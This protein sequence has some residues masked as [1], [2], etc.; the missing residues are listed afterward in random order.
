MTTVA[1][2]A[3][4]GAAVAAGLIATLGAV[5]YRRRS[6]G[7]LDDGISPFDDEFNNSTLSNPL[8]AET[9]QSGTN[10]LFESKS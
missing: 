1:I 2:A 5:M 9:G 4:L 6:K 3:G 10:P 8:Y 7:F